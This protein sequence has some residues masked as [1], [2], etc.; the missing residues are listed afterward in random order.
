LVSHFD[1]NVV[2][3]A[4]NVFYR[5]FAPLITPASSLDAYAYTNTNPITPKRKRYTAD[6]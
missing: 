5:E 6:D 3:V 4:T 1:S 2:G